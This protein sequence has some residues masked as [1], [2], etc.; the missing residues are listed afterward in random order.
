LL[1]NIIAKYRRK[2]GIRKVE[3]GSGKTV[4]NQLPASTEE[5]GKTK[6]YLNTTSGKLVENTKAFE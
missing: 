6:P 1:G 2:A 3:G 5:R 4:T